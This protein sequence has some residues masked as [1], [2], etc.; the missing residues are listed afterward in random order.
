MVNFTTNN[1]PLWISLTDNLLLLLLL[2]IK[3]HRKFIIIIIIYQFMQDI[4]SYVLETM[5]LGCT[6]LQVVCSYNFWYM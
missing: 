1:I 2:W 5:S 6:V 3:S 4:Y